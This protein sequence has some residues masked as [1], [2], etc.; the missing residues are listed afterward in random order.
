MFTRT[1]YIPSRRLIGFSLAGLFALSAAANTALAQPSAEPTTGAVA[2]PTPSYA[3]ALASPDWGKAP[4]GLAYK[5][6][7]HAVP[8]GGSV[9]TNGGR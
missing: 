3:Q 8:A 6:C 5:G 4:F 7:V 2:L 9:D 1:N